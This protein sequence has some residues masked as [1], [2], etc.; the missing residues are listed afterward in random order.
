MK[1]DPHVFLCGQLVDT[2]HSPLVKGI[3]RWCPNQIRTFPV[4]E[5]LMNSAAMGM[6]LAGLRPVM[7]HERFDFAMVGMDALVNHIPIWRKK[8]GIKLPLVILAIRGFGKGQGPQQNKDFTTFFTRIEG[9][10]VMKPVSA[11]EA[12]DY[13]KE[14]IFGEDPV[15]YVV[16]REFFDL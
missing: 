12:Y 10:K 11:I 13:M 6:S 16:H 5:N 2:N 4:S 8:C 14:A 9:W 7:M 15:L 3:K 1:Q